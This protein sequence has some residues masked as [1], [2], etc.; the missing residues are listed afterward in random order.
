M[1]IKVNNKEVNNPVLKIF[2]TVF[3]LFIAGVILTIVGI[4]LLSPFLVSL[5]LL[6]VIP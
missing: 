1:T 3:A 6:G 2:Y 5:Y 4:A